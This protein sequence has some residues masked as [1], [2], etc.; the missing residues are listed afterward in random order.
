MLIIVVGMFFHLCQNIAFKG[1]PDEYHPGGIDTKGE[2]DEYYST[3]SGT[4]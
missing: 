1:G 2:P 3:H 4:E